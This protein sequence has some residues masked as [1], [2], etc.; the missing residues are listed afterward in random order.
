MQFRCKPVSQSHYPS[1]PLSP[2]PSSSIFYR[3]SIYVTKKTHVPRIFEAGSMETNSR[4]PLSHLLQQQRH[5]LEREEQE[6]WKRHVRKMES[7]EEHNDYENILRMW[8]F[9][10][11]KKF[12]GNQSGV[13]RTA[14]S[15]LVEKS[16]G[17]AAGVGAAPVAIADTHQLLQITPSSS[18]SAVRKSV[19]M[20]SKRA[21]GGGVLKF[22][23]APPQQQQ[24]PAARAEIDQAAAGR[25]LPMEVKAEEEEELGRLVEI[26]GESLE[27]L[28]QILQVDGQITKADW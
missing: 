18:S 10:S 15:T 19:I 16:D 26:P 7:I 21:G 2:P 28:E 11:H 3:P 13:V 17:M 5:S 8:D 22:G 6:R 20:I 27:T 25:D 12:R 1:T 23:P 9:Y 24:L 4:L 14:A